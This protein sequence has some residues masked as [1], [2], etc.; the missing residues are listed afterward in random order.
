MIQPADRQCFFEA[1]FFS[2]SRVK[3]DT[4]VWDRTAW[5]LTF[6]SPMNLESI[7]EMRHLFLGVKFQR[8]VGIRSHPHVV[9]KSPKPPMQEGEE[10][11]GQSNKFLG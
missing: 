9:H 8:Q 3:K 10:E 5:I 4:S 7:P 2:Q 11:E 6:L 1:I